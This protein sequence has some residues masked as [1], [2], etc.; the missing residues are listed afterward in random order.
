MR[1]KRM[2]PMAVA[3][4]VALPFVANAQSEGQPHP[5]DATTPSAEKGPMMEKTMETC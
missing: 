2:I 5:H 1:N 3:L 4:L